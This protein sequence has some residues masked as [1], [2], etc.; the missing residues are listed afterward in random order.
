M[1]DPTKNDRHDDDAPRLRIEFTKEGL[2]EIRSRVREKP[3]PTGS[4][5]PLANAAINGDRFRDSRCR[6]CWDHGALYCFAGGYV[7]ICSR[8]AIERIERLA[9][10]GHELPPSVLYLYWEAERELRAQAK[11]ERDKLSV[12]FDDI[13]R[14]SRCMRPVVDK[15][16]RYWG[17]EGESV[18]YPFCQEC[19][20]MIA[21]GREE[22]HERQQ[23]EFDFDV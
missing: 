18:L 23:I 16:V 15:D 3:S 1:S 8:C 7:S 2:R 12:R 20:E 13:C 19:R 4:E 10:A 14:C 9:A 17:R 6:K 5:I 22:F 21:S 11:R